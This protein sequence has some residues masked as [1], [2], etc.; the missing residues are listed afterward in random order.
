M[1]VKELIEELQL[2]RDKNKDIEVQS[3]DFNWSITSIE[4]VINN[5]YKVILVSRRYYD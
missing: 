1:T 4:K 2:I 5:D 3:N